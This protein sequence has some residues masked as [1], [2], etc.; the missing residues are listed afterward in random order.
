MKKIL[1][2]VVLLLSTQ[3]NCN[4]IE[5]IREEVKKEIISAQNSDEYDDLELVLLEPE[6][7]TN[8]HLLIN[9]LCKKMNIDMPYACVY[10]GIYKKNNIP[11][12]NKIIQPKI[13]KIKDLDKSNAFISFTTFY[14]FDRNV[15]SLG[16]DIINNLSLDELEAIIAHELGHVKNFNS[17]LDVLISNFFVKFFLSGIISTL[18]VNTVINPINGK[19]ISN[20]MFKSKPIVINSTTYYTDKSTLYYPILALEIII[21]GILIN[22]IFSKISRSREKKADLIAAEYIKDPQALAQAL[23]KLNSLSSL[24]IKKIIKKYLWFL[25]SH[26]T[27]KQ[28]TKYL[29]EVAQNLA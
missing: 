3:L 20:L 26:P 2:I 19:F 29:T 4:N 23:N 5:K 15:L 11:I 16:I 22:G 6:N 21:T 1:F 7:S 17:V 8:I 10:T 18:F 27:L 28:R 24:K 13:N 25:N 14:G 12:Y 9:N